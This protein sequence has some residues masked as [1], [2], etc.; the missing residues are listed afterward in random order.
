MT[1]LSARA[2]RL[3]EACDR[4]FGVPEQAPAADVIELRAGQSVPVFSR[5]VAWDSRK[6]GEAA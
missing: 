2:A 4:I 3:M 1:P 6:Q 5:A